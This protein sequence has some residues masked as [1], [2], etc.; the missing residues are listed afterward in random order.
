MEATSLACNPARLTPR[1]DRRPGRL[2]SL[3]LAGVF[4]G[5]SGSA[6]AAGSPE[7][8]TG[9]VFVAGSGSITNPSASALQVRQS[10]ARGVIDWR[11]FSIGQGGVVTI[12]N[13]QGATLNR[14]TGG[15]MSILRGGLTATGS[16]Y[17]VNPQGV[18]VG[19]E[20]R[21]LAGGT[22]GL[23]TRDIATSAFM[24][25]GSLNARGDSVGEVTNLGRILSRR[26]DVFLVGASV[27]NGGEISAPG[28][29]AGLAAGDDVLMAPADGARGLYVASGAGRGDVTAAGKIDAASAE[30]ISAGGSVYTLAGNR[31]GSIQATSV[32]NAGGQVWLSAPEGE[33]RVDGRVEARNGGQIT[34]S[35]RDVAVGSGAVLDASGTSG[36]TV[37]VGVT[38]SQTGLSRSTTIA[39]GATLLAGGPAGGGL[40]ETSGR[41]M[42]IGDAVIRAG[43][44]GQW[45]VDPVDLTIN[46][47]AASTIVSALN[48]GTNVTQVTD[49]TSAAG[50]GVQ[51]PGEGDI[52]VAAPISWTGSGSLTLN[53]YRD[54]VVSSAI[55]GTGSGGLTLLAGRNISTTAAVTA[56]T[57]NF[58]ATTGGITTSASGALSGPNGVTLNAAQGISLGAG[59]TNASSG[60]VQVTGGA[61]VIL[62]GAVDARSVTVNANGGTLQTGAS[63]T[64]TGQNGV[65]LYGKTGVTLGAAVTN[66]QAGAGALSVVSDGAL[67]ATGG[68]IGRTVTLN[69]T[70]GALTA[71][72]VRST[73]GGVTLSARDNLTLSGALTAQG[74]ATATA[75]QAL[76]AAG[77]AGSS[78]VSLTA[79]GGD[80]STSGAVTGVGGVSYRA[81]GSVTLGS[82]VANTGSGALSVSAGGGV[83]VSGAAS[84]PTVT[85][86]ANGGDLNIGASG[87]ISGTNGVTLGTIG[88][89]ING[90]GATGVQSSAGRWLIY[91]T[92]PTTDTIGGLSF[93]FIQYAAAYPA[94]GVGATAPAQASGN[95]LLYS[96]APILTFDLTG[97][98]AK[99][100][101]GNATATLAP[102][103]IVATGL[104]GADTLSLSAVYS[105]ANAGD[106]I[107]VTASSA[108]VTNG[109]KP[110]YGYTLPSP[111]VTAYIGSIARKSLS[112]SIV[113]NPT[114]VYN[115]STLANLT[116]A[117]FQISGFVGSE[118]A[119]VVST[120]GA[121]YDSDQAGARTVTAGLA[122]TSFAPTGGTLLSN[123]ILPTSAS[124]SGTISTATLRVV[125]VLSGNKT[126]D[127]TT[128]ASLDLSQ[129]LLFGAVAGDSLSLNLASA[130]GDYASANVG[131]DQA[132]TASGF[133]V[134]GAAA[135]NYT[136]IQPQGLRGS[137]TARTL[138]ITG[139][140][141]QNKIYDGTTTATLN[142]SG[143][144][145]T[146]VVASDVGQVSLNTG[147]AFANFESANANPG[148]KVTA[149]GFLLAGAKASNYT[150]S[151]QEMYANITPRPLTATIS[152]NPTKTYNGTTTANVSTAAYGLSG[153]VA[154]QGA[155]LTPKATAYYD[156]ANAGDRTV[157]ATLATPDFTANVG[158][159]LANY[160]L[161]T[162][163]TGVGTITKAAVTFNIVGNPS[164]VYDANNVATLGSSNFQAVGLM[165]VDSL[166]VTQT[167]GTYASA[168]AG[169]WLVTADL[170]GKISGSASLFNNYTFATSASG[171][172]T[173]RQA[174]LTEGVG[175]VFN[176]N[177]RIV[178]NPTKVYD[179]T[180]ILT[181][182]TPANFVLTGLQGTD[183]IQVVKT[184]GVFESVNA[185]GQS[186]RVDLNSNPSTTTD[187]LAG[188]GTLLSNY[189]LPSALFGTGTITPKP[190]T[191][192]L[193]GT[194]TKVY[195]GSNIAVLTSANYV[196]SGLVGSDDIVVGQAAQ[197]FYDS[198]NAGAR[199]V[200]V[201]L[202]E[203]DLQAVGATRLSNYI[204]PGSVTGTG[205]ISQ[206]P[207][208]IL[209]AR[210]NDKTYD[211]TNV[212]SLDMSR[213][214]LFGI[215]AGETVSLNS[216]A[217][218]ATF[219]Q[220][221][222]GS[223]LSVTATGFTLLG[224]GASNYALQPLTG[225]TAAI[226]PK[227]L[228]ISGVVANSRTYNATTNATL[229]TS[230]ATLI[231]VL[232]GDVGQVSLSVA[233]ASASFISAFVR[234]GIPVNAAGFG[235]SGAKAAN[236]SVQQPTGL[237]ANITPAPLSAVVTGNPTK[238][239][240][241]STAANVPAA[242]IAV[243]G[244][245]GTDGATVHQYAA[246]SFASADAGT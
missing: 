72:G 115:R 42:T 220:S 217:A 81:S 232:G 246:S 185:G 43:E 52:T 96:L 143:L 224:A 113:G 225:L 106:L 168:N 155:T 21:I 89:F 73:V 25:G 139:L 216:G 154:G 151:T 241:A 146:G 62:S 133:A 209:Y 211:G 70:G 207:L 17:L 103:N 104:V 242:S 32:R 38:A 221:N 11:S 214:I 101:D 18:V 85:M 174:P 184:T 180:D 65:T 192:N 160:I 112:A 4:A 46:A 28:G 39:S 238:T 170:T 93:G 98:V 230:G 79:N 159:I 201:T 83:T 226:N 193:T 148:L 181:G 26:G 51:T 71:A 8:P 236:Y 87:S 144:S 178:G 244:F 117:N 243:S 189:I 88:N 177:G 172:G 61:G 50:V 97:T 194:P 197:A 227:Q 100:Y 125:G 126:Y 210:A 200:S 99:T 231:G 165:G 49:A 123:Y 240:D 127:G 114:K 142:L 182:L 44:G 239:Y 74:A 215:V 118:G 69:A 188:A 187:Y 137:I 149:S 3:L 107:G 152:G 237:S 36:G 6:L 166:T 19:P 124:G 161:P 157:S 167:T 190:V 63:A 208:R 147:S 95:G 198:P 195:N 116:S 191:I 53:A 86:S 59:V 202:K 218:T 212:A 64:L 20:G 76:S 132:I 164:K 120:T 48:S 1:R 56:S 245:F 136:L 186:I 204:L 77:V 84:G 228:S 94:D 179:G 169:S 235:L 203:T 2:K 162:A 16:V 156:S 9:G 122:H 75:G 5:V 60:Q 141:A 41:L 234:N 102:G 173:I 37:L 223:G 31:A 150:V 91:S 183:T 108:S 153:F 7:L 35:G 229:D 219:S 109:G 163:A 14:V 135:A 29:V 140:S 68:I 24:G 233:G 176:L 55:N 15:Q 158:T 213:A 30:L 47:A 10:T 54:V 110:V 27:L 130:R 45:L 119:T 111:S 57:L 128:T 12:L 33:V 40:V 90:R 222:A 175:P 196:F 171:M 23:S 134:S 131:A 138:S 145:L 58:T 129:A 82:S 199:T 22:I 121:D 78:T 66:P 67:S 105:S 80:L 13:G 205:A 206:A 92:S 34:V